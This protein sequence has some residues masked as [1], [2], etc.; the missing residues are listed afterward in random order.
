M[1]S[2]HLLLLRAALDVADKGIP[3]ADMSGG[4]P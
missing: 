3:I 1:I 2:S 4:E